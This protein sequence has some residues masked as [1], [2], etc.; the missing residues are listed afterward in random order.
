MAGTL[1]EPGNTVIFGQILG[2]CDV[3]HQAFPC[4]SLNGLFNAFSVPAATAAVYLPEVHPG[5]AVG[6]QGFWHRATD[7]KVLC[8][9]V[10]GHTHTHLTTKIG[11][12]AFE[13]AVNVVVNMKCVTNAQFFSYGGLKNTLDMGEFLTLTN[14]QRNSTHCRIFYYV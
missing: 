14:I 4:E 13:A 3:T 5:G 11:V 2:C 10:F 12:G 1:S 8:M 7:V 6:T 9:L